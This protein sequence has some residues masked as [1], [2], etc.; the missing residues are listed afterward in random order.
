MQLDVNPRSKSKSKD[1]SNTPMVDSNSLAPERRSK[2]I[3]EVS[4]WRGRRRRMMMMMMM[5][6]R[7]RRRRRRARE[8]RSYKKTGTTM[9]SKITSPL[10]LTP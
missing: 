10:F 7:R 5:R 2:R 4:N 9:N 6:R 1:G 3:A 8:D